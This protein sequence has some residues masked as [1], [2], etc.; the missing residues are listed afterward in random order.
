MVCGQLAVNER[1]T[2]REKER[3]HENERRLLARHLCASASRRSR[4]LF[5]FSA[6]LLPAA[7]TVSIASLDTSDRYIGSS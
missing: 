5:L 2:E 6:L 4:F 3:L 7:V 1:E